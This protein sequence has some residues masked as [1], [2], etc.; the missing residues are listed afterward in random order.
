VHDGQS[1]LQ[2]TLA[3]VD[4]ARTVVVGPVASVRLPAGVLT[5]RE[6]PPFGGPVAAI[7]AGLRALAVTHAERSGATI[8]LAC[9][10]PRVGEVVP[11]LLAA[12]A[13]H[14][15]FDGVIA[16]DET[17]HR[18]PLAAVYR[19]EPLAA[20]LA[21]LALRG[22]LRSRPMFRLIDELD[23][24]SI[25]VPDG[26]TADVDTWDDAARLGITTTPPTND[27]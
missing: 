6:E 13:G 2:S 18:Q 26:A 10:M 5:T 21:T 20:A 27:R 12:L 17:G 4:G 19:S 25:A 24:V 9:D 3:A 23:L 16:V 8:V 11:V 14:P 7:A 22:S 15:A 1:L